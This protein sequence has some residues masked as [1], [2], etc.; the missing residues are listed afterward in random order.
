MVNVV[1]DQTESLKYSLEDK[2]SHVL[3][4]FQVGRAGASGWWSQ[5]HGDSQAGSCWV[6]SV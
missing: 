5:S 1:Y 2:L 4:C 3:V 6:Q